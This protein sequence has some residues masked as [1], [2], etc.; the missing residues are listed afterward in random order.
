M[1]DF[2]TR[3][4]H[5]ANGCWRYLGPITNAGYGMFHDVGIK[6]RVLAHRFAFERDHS[7]TLPP[8]SARVCLD[9]LCRNRWCVNPGHL[10]LVTY[11][12]NLLRGAG[13]QAA[14]NVAKTRCPEGHDL[15]GMN[16]YTN[17][18][19]GRRHC[20]TCRKAHDRRARQEGRK[21]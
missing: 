20:R 14:R 6:K 1:A 5:E 19:T 8:R 21:H 2:D 15:S 4:R 3:V 12:E 9:H 10:E 13:T 7:L 16:L 17:P 11:R 18:R